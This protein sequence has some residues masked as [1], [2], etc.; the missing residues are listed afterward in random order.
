MAHGLRGDNVLLRRDC[1]PR[2]VFFKEDVGKAL[3]LYRPPWLSDR[4]QS[5][6][7]RRVAVWIDVD[8]L[9][10]K[11]YLKRLLPYAG[12]FPCA[13]Y[14]DPFVCNVFESFAQDSGNRA[15]VAVENG[16][17]PPRLEA[18]QVLARGGG[19]R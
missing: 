4:V 12:Q 15:S 16:G 9:L 7:H 8:G 11:R 10:A 14:K 17:N 3:A 6:K 5:V 13:I 19:G 1:Q 2:T 18:D